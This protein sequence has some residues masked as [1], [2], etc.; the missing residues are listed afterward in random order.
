MFKEADL[1][2]SNFE[3]VNLSP[4][5]VFDGHTENDLQ[6]KQEFDNGDL[7]SMDFVFSLFG[8][9]YTKDMG[10]LGY[11]NIHV[12]STEVR[13]NDIIVS[14]IFI[15]NF[16]GAN[17]ENANFKN[18]NLGFVYFY[19]ANFTNANLSGADLRK[20]LLE[21]ADLRGADLTGAD[22]SGANLAGANLAGA[23]L[24]GVVYDQHTILKCVGHP[25]CVN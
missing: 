11:P 23:N 24:A 4:V 12:V 14:F 1:S 7:N 21:K 16:S 8:T 22:I 5:Q 20:T 2:D 10:F 6:L 13:G 3:G 9:G 17:L 25:I 18:A 15:N 19:S